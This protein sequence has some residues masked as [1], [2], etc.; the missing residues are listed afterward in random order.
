M[1][2]IPNGF[3]LRAFGPNPEARAHF[4]TELGLDDHAIAVGMIG[5]FVPLKNHRMFLDAATS[6][7]ERCP[8]TRFVLAGAGVDGENAELAAWIGQTGLPDRFHLLGQ[9]PDMPKLMAGLDLLAMPSRVEAFPMVLGEAM[10]CGVP[11]IAADVGD[12]ALI[13][14]KTGRIVPPG[15]AMALAGAL[16]DL[17]SLPFEVR[18][19]LG[20]TARERI[21]ERYDIETVAARYT[22]HWLALAGRSPLCE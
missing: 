4:R 8:S 6:V 2:L 12:A 22:D 13:I 14:G 16:V 18:R 1:L 3:D 7:G 21:A 19:S 15:D 10:A 9:R 20:I 5:R 17:A 11:C